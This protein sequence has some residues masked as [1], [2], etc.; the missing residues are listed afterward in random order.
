ME[1]G[2]GAEQE[3]GEVDIDLRWVV[4]FAF[5]LHSIYR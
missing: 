4:V 3:E 1:R 5:L 2:L